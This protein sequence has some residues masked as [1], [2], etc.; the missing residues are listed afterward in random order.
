V[1]K[2]FPAP[3]RSKMFDLLTLGSGTTAGSRGHHQFDY[4]SPVA[5][6]AVSTTSIKRKLDST[7]K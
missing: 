4:D 2:H 7:G 3:D 6:P 1:D 5:S